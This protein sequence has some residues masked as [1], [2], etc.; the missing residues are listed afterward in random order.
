MLYLQRYFA[1]ALI[2]FVLLFSVCA[3]PENVSARS[4][5]SE[6]PDSLLTLYLKS[7]L[8]VVASI[9]SE[10]VLKMTSEYEYGSYFDIEKLLDVSDTL[11]G[12][13]KGR[14]AYVISQYEPKDSKTIGDD[15]SKMASSEETD[16]FLSIGHKALFFL[17]KN[18]ENNSYEL[19]DYGSAIKK[20]SD[21]DL[22]IYL[23]RIKE[24]KK[25]TEAK[26]N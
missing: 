2:I 10:K 21:H 26:K 12:S 25:I 8:I 1:S 13:R 18:A 16:D 19:A 6:P 5:P 3:L 9:E 7:D 24:L 22:N 15:S 23:K 4:C 11:K 17:V 20:L 14:T